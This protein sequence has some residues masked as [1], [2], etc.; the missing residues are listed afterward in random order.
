M[1]GES[2]EIRKARESDISAIV[3]LTVRAWKGVTFAEM[4]EDKYGIVEGR[5]WYSY[6]SEEIEEFCRSSLDKVFVAEEE[7]KIVGYAIYTLDF[8]RKMGT[9]GSNAVD[10]D[11][12]NRGIGSALHREVL[13]QMKREGM[14]FAFVTTMVN[15]LPARRMYEKHGFVELCRS[16]HYIQKLQ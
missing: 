4:I 5:R 1:R 15:D 13:S 2:M 11:Y 16:I 12:R 6:K 3:S 10:P 9:V 8:A 7:G 14:I